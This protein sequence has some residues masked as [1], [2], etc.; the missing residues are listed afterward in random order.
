MDYDEFMDLFRNREIGIRCGK[1]EERT[2]V[3]EYFLSV[4]FSRESGNNYLRTALAEVDW[5]FPN[6]CYR[7]PYYGDN[8]LSFY[9]DGYLEID[10]EIS[11]EQFFNMVE[12]KGW[13]IQ[14]RPIREL[15]G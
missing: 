2:A 9:S 13:C 3:I 12:D 1:I 10:Q 11:A 4:G 5:K 6:V 7:D 8:M 15:F 14:P